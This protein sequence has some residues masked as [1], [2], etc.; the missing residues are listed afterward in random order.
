MHLNQLKLVNFLKIMIYYS[1]L[2]LNIYWK[3][4]IKDNN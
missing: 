1:K 2:P 3:E 4:E